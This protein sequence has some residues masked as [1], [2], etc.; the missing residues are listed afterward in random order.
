MISVM[1]GC[2]YDIMQNLCDSHIEDT[3]IVGL[4]S[5]ADVCG[6]DFSHDCKLTYRTRIQLN[7][8]KNFILLSN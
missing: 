5:L 3:S 2:M 4:Q 8:L 6:I 1:Y 7:I